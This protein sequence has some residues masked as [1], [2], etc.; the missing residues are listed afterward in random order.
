MHKQE[1]TAAGGVGRTDDMDED[2][3]DPLDAFMNE[4]AA[5]A[6]APPKRPV[7]KPVEEEEL[8]PLDAFM[9]QNTAP[10]GS[11]A[12][13]KAEAVTPK[14][15]PDAELDPLDA[16]MAAEI[17]PVANGPSQAAASSQV[18]LL[19]AML[20]VMPS[21]QEAQPC[22]MLSH[23]CLGLM[24]C[25]CSQALAGLFFPGHSFH[26]VFLANQSPQPHLLGAAYS[27]LPSDC[28]ACAGDEAAGQAGASRGRRRERGCRA[29]CREAAP[30]RSAAP[31]A[32]PALLQQRV[33]R[34]RRGR[35]GRV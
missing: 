21:S 2:D 7:R 10:A 1:D 19:R 27:S 33:L 32:A 4:N 18:S 25:K 12:A 31:A 20:C 8:D 6:S 14:Q 3:I 5:K 22:H 29:A 28:C 24:H 16:F 34:R 17:N 26:N 11:A 30:Q 9:A 15:E 13:V 35:S 23:A